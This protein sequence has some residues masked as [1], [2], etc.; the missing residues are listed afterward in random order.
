MMVKTSEAAVGIA[1]TPAPFAHC[2]KKIV[3]ETIDQMNHV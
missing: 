2:P 3:H 1:P